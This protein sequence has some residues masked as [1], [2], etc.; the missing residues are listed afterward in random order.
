MRPKERLSVQFLGSRSF[1]RDKFSDEDCYD[2]V[3]I[4]DYTYKSGIAASAYA[5]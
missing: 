4:V 3:V 1:K 5:C 2:S